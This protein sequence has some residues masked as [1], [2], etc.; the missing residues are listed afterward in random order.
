MNRRNFIKTTLPVALL[1]TT[2]VTC[3]Y[4]YDEEGKEKEANK[5]DFPYY[6]QCYVKE[7]QEY[8]FELYDKG[9]F[10][11][12]LPIKDKNR[13]YGWMCEGRLRFT[14]IESA[15]D[16]VETHARVI[17]VKAEDVIY[18]VYKEGESTTYHVG[19]FWYDWKTGRE[20]IWTEDKIINYGTA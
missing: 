13:Y 10:D 6:I 8:V 19:H 2:T 12:N 20:I 14:D 7:Q 4:E 9:S 11:K 16:F 17:N 15:T 18:D 5:K 1:A 3:K